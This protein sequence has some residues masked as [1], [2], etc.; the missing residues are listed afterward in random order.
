MRAAVEYDLGG[1]ATLHEGPLSE[2][3]AAAWAD[4]PIGLHRLHWQVGEATGVSTLIVAP[5]RFAA[6]GRRTPGLAVFAPVHS[7]W[8]RTEPL[9]AYD[10]L[11]V[12][13][14]AVR[15]FGVESIATLPLY[16]GGLGDRFDPS[17]YAPLSRFHWNEVFVP[18]RLLGS[19]AEPGDEGQRA[20]RVDWS[21]VVATRTG[22]L[23]PEH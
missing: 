19:A 16:A 20:D 8:T 2:L 1:E 14:A 6:P 15:P 22:Q 12:L 7:I 17:P 21:H 9:P 11:A 4:Q 13:G 5:R 10:S 3:T 23:T 18:D